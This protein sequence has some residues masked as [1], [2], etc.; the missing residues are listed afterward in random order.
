MP[1]V[2]FEK[3]PAEQQAKINRLVRGVGLSGPITSA[4]ISENGDVRPVVLEQR[5]LLLVRPLTSL[6]GN[7]SAGY[8]KLAEHRIFLD[9]R[10]VTFQGKTIL[11]RPYTQTVL[12]DGSP[13]ANQEAAVIKSL[14]MQ[15]KCLKDAQ[16]RH[17]NLTA[18]N[19]G[20]TGANATLL[21]IA[22]HDPLS[23][24][25]DDYE[26]LALLKIFPM[27]A[28]RPR[29]I[30][31][32]EAATLDQAESLV[33]E[34]LSPHS[35]SG[36]I[37]VTPSLTMAKEKARR[38][39]V[40]PKRQRALG[41]LVISFL[42][43]GWLVYQYRAGE[44]ILV[45]DR[46]VQQLKISNST[47]AN[48]DLLNRA[49]DSRWKAELTDQDVATALLLAAP[50]SAKDLLPDIAPAPIESLHPGVV[51]AA[52]SMIP[53]DSLPKQM[54]AFPLAR[55]EALPG[56][57]GKSFTDIRQVEISS[58]SSAVVYALAKAA[59]G[60]LTFEVATAAF[61]EITQQQD[62][63]TLLLP[64][65][66]ALQSSSLPV[67]LEAVSSLNTIVTRR[68]GWFGGNETA[69]WDGVPSPTK[70]AI[71]SDIAAVEGLTFE[72]KAD[73]LS[74]D[75]QPIRIAALAAIKKETKQKVS[76][77]FLGLLIAEDLQLNRFQKFSLATALLLNESD[78]VDF[79]ER[80]LETGPDAQAVV[81][82][83]AT[84]AQSGQMDGLSLQAARYLKERE[85]TAT[86]SVLKQL[87]LHPETLVRALAFAKLDVANEQHL[88]ILKEMAS[89]DPDP[90]IK[91][92]AQARIS[93]EASKE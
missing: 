14:L 41:A 92:E 72:Q 30:T 66:V 51:L 35:P 27:V 60:A 64:R 53:S 55:F 13:A 9:S 23:S 5:A 32:L 7:A 71:V 42:V 62:H 48:F 93:L 81:R 89:R 11:I 22:L 15:L 43:L 16:V 46:I 82:L 76:D 38:R 78:F 21:D 37:I 68:L 91:K 59:F 12:S 31:A 19:V 84:R 79:F 61:T 47:P 80:W 28:G 86:D 57:L 70:V 83:I 24:A 65:L 40:L 90:R 58:V 25:T 39:I 6:A 49:F 50:A 75:S 2:T 77:E 18:S 56:I 63:S 34:A 44:G 67:I 36:K 73:L 8:K 74:F 52:I 85:W 1:L 54:L 33:E 45:A 3:L 4:L 17:G 20:F 29:L 69:Q 87:S 10:L 88:S 26:W